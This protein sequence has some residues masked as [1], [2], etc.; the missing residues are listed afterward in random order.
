MRQ[1]YT[2]SIGLNF[3]V[4]EDK[5]IQ[6]AGKHKPPTLHK[7]AQRGSARAAPGEVDTRTRVQARISANT[8]T[9]TPRLRILR[10]ILSTPS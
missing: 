9:S 2:I 4:A 5:L 10:K 8:T 6:A 7:L 1:P 3:A